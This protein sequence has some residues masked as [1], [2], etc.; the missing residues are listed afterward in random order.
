MTDTP[1]SGGHLDEVLQSAPTGTPSWGLGVAFIL[2]TCLSPFVAV[3]LA[4]SPDV[5]KYLT[6]KQQVEMATLEANKV[7]S[8]KNSESVLAI[9]ASYSQQVEMLSTTLGELRSEKSKLADK[10]DLLGR[11]IDLIKKS[12]EACSR[13]LEICKGS[14]PK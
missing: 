1:D 3:Y 2:A 5:G 13:E 12:G 10:V 6:G 7:L 9:V 11:E 4:I 8:L 14:L